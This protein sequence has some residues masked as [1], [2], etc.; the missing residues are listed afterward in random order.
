MVPLG[1]LGD[2]QFLT[3]FVVL[4]NLVGGIDLGLGLLVDENDLLRLLVL[5]LHFVDAHCKLLIPEHVIVVS[6]L[7]VQCLGPG[8]YQPMG[9]TLGR[10]LVFLLSMQVGRLLFA[11]LLFGILQGQ[12]QSAILELFGGSVR[13]P[14]HS[15]D[16][17]RARWL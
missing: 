5:F 4:C 10:G 6:M 14:P 1:P 12:T 11:G 2:G 17:R 7:L 13:H 16:I 9:V 15:N 3:E 8:V